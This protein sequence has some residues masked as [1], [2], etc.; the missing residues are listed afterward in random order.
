MVMVM[1]EPQTDLLEVEEQ[2]TVVADWQEEIDTVQEQEQ[3]QEQE[4][5]QGQGQEHNSLLKV[6]LAMV[7]EHPIAVED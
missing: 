2:L 7:E 3:E 1:V 5:G 4:Q 6:L